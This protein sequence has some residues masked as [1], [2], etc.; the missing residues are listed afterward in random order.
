MKILVFG[1]YFSDNLGDGVIC[2]CVKALLQ[3]R[4]LWD[5]VSIMDLRNRD[6]F[7]MRGVKSVKAIR[8]R[9]CRKWLR[10]QISRM[11][12]VDKQY[13]NEVNRM[14][15]E[16][17]Y[18]ERLREQECDLVIV[19]GGQLFMDSYALRLHYIT[20]C[21]AEKGIPIIYNACGAGPNYSKQ[22]RKCLSETLENPGVYGVSCRDDV[23]KINCRYTMASKRTVPT[24]D[25]ALGC[26]ECYGVVRD[27]ESDV[28]GLGIMAPTRSTVKASCFFWA[29]LIR[30]LERKGIK[31]KAFVNG[32]GSDYTFARYVLEAVPGLDRPIEECLVSIP[33]YPRELVETISQF[34]SI[35]S[36]RLHSHIIAASLDIPSVAVVWDDKVRFFFEKIGH[37]ERCCR[38]WD[39]PQKV[40][41]K[42]IAA[43]KEGYDRALIEEQ[44]HY[45]E[46][47]LFNAIESTGLI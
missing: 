11:G 28:I 12:I 8:K 22:I 34:K 31:W 17:E 26:S 20:K 25:P 9:E 33:L 44:K 45:S 41:D 43:E 23:E 32:S 18:F 27:M 29:R 30:E 16:R 35:I 4:C 46:K 36:F 6:Q 19:A 14:T 42:L 5:E 10:A 21:F 47:W 2:E 3:K 15:Q 38:L 37:S 1:S 39:R 7:Q 13:K 24:Y 40:L